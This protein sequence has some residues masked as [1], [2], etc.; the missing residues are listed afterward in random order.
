MLRLTCGAG[1]VQRR[2][3][4]T[5]IDHAPTD[6]HVIERMYNALVH[7]AEDTETPFPKARSK[8]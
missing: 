5:H 1:L 7:A 8:R 4:G 2:H 3:A 6:Q